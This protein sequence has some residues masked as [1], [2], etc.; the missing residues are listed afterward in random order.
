MCLHWV[1]LLLDWFKWF[2][3]CIS[4][5]FYDQVLIWDNLCCLFSIEVFECFCCIHV[6]WWCSVMQGAVQIHFCSVPFSWR[7]FPWCFPG[8]SFEVCWS[9]LM[10]PV[11]F[12]ALQFQS[13]GKA[14]H[15]EC[16]FVCV[17]FPVCYDPPLYSGTCVTVFQSFY[18]LL[19]VYLGYGSVGFNHA[20]L[21]IL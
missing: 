21:S 10:S 15:F 17:S 20:N 7:V 6:S 4:M 2:I 11:T 5:H 16:V 3:V 13:T 8:C 14:V 9:A 19:L 1:C 12:A 18:T